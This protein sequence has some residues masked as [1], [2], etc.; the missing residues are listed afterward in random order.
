MSEM[1]KMP[2]VRLVRA[3]EW[4]RARVYGLHQKMMPAPVVMLELVHAGNTSQAIQV[5]ASL[6]IA[7]VLVDGPLTPEEIAAKVGANADGVNRLLR[8]LAGSGIFHADKSG[9][10]RLTPLADTLRRDAEMPMRSIAMFTNSPEHREHWAHLSEAVR[11]GKPIIKNLRGMDVWTF[12]EQ[13][14]GANQ[15]F[16][17]AMSDFSNFT[18]APILSAYDFN[19]FPTIVDVGGGQ[20]AML[21]AILRRTPQA[22]GIVYDLP[23]VEGAEA[24]LRAAGVLDRCT[25]EAG[26][27][28]EKVPSGGDAYVLKNVIH[29][30]PDAEVSTMLRN[31]RQAINPGGRLLIIELIIPEGNGAH[32]GKMGDLDMLLLVGGR[33]RTVAE[34]RTLL[35]DAGFRL[36]RV[37]QT[38]SPLSILEATPV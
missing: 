16:N 12:F 22:K 2:P 23:T 1:Q 37:V 14:E 20:G 25:V 11:T 18:L 36:D 3:V 30:W 32:P 9:R 38:A 35:S 26:S 15:V 4:L 29:N 5:A 21:A 19:R 7:D 27:A 8:G 10:Y 13:N 34:S 33:E 31:I 17:D 24:T 28:L 6:G